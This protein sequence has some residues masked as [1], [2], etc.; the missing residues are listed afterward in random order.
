MLDPKCRAM[1][2]LEV[3]FVKILESILSLLKLK[4][5]NNSIRPFPTMCTLSVF[6]GYYIKYT[7]HTNLSY[8]HKYKILNKSS[9]YRNG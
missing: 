7:Y 8:E 3:L 9:N 6:L 5:Y 1:Y 4:G 2:L